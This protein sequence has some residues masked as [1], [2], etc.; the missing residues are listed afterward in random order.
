MNCF[1][2]HNSDAIDSN[3]RQR[4][5]DFWVRRT[6]NDSFTQIRNSRKQQNITEKRDHNLSQ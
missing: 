3:G 4:P 1:L 2:T 5:R 6:K